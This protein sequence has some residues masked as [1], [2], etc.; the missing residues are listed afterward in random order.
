MTSKKRACSIGQKCT[1]DDS[2]VRA[3]KASQIPD[4][5]QRQEQESTADVVFAA[6][7]Q[8]ARLIWRRLL[9]IAFENFLLLHGK[10]AAKFLSGDKLRA[11]LPHTLQ[12]FILGTKV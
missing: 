4:I 5:F 11:E 1:T 2:S 10:Q 6:R 8:F 3:R 7:G 9:D 12:F